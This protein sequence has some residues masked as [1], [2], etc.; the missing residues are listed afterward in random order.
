MTITVGVHDTTHKQ[1]PEA[2]ENL[3]MNKNKVLKN[4]ETHP[5][6]R[7]QIPYLPNT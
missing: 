1:T 7:H 4:H 5:S 6:N 3:K 2:L